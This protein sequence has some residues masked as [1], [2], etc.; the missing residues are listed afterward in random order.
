MLWREIKAHILLW[1]IV[2][3][4]QPN[5]PVGSNE[6]TKITAQITSKH[7][8]NPKQTPKILFAKKILE[9]TSSM[10]ANTNFKSMQASL[11][12]THKI[13]KAMPITAYLE[14]T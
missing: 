3:C 1:S 12:T 13:T 10:R 8:K 7:C 14:Q 5:A 4:N 6:T 9:W 11:T 2:R